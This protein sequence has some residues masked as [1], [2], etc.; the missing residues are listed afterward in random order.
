MSVQLTPRG[1]QV[2]TPGKDMQVS[3]ASVAES[4]EQIKNLS[5]REAFDQIRA[6]W[7]LVTIVLS[8][9]IVLALAAGG[10]LRPSG[11]RN[12]GTRDVK[13]FPAMM[14]L[15]AGVMVILAQQL[16]MTWAASVPR[17]V[18]PPGDDG[19][20]TLR[21][22][23]ATQAIGGL[24]AG[25]VGIGLFAIMAK[26]APEGGLKVGGLDPLVGLGCLLLALPLVQLSSM[27]AEWAYRE[28]YGGE[29]VVV[30]HTTLRMI[31][32]HRHDPMAWL[33][34]GAVVIGAPLIEEL[35]FRAGLQS[36]ALKLTG[37]PWAAVV[38]T[39]AIFTAMHI[40]AVPAEGRYAL[41]QIFVLSIAMGIAYERTRRLG[42]PIVMHIGFNGLMVA[43]A[44]SVAEQPAAAA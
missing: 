30:A 24:V 1:A 19:A 33:L 4:L 31:V 34:I 26:T 41:V 23:A 7:P 25:M 22:A 13:P 36:A 2:P 14:W 27:G 35:A 18:G 29:P 44:L 15:F 8:V 37:S 42:V 32:D 3:A 17:L 11:F 40:P 10:V 38:G 6:V 9:V 39:S 20:M 43:L 16:A 12:S 28:L 21:F 5:V